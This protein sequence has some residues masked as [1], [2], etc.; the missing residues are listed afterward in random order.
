MV[1]F[2]RGCNFRCPA[3]HAKVFLSAEENNIDSFDLWNYLSRRRKSVGAVVLCGGE[4][5]VY[6]DIDEFIVK[7]KQFGYDVKLDTNG[8]NPDILEKLIR[9]KLID[10]VAMDIK[11]PPELYSNVCGTDIDISRIEKSIKI[12]SGFSN[13]EFRTTLV[14]FYDNDKTIRFLD[15]TDIIK[16]A[17]WLK[18]VTANASHKYFIQKFVSR[19]EKLLDSRM[20]QYEPTPSDIAKEVCMEAKKVLPVCTVR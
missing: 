19:N 13:Y 6:P 10:Y 16:I 12:L 14:P 15:K 8:G 3:C 20:E 17:K 1:L 7:I 4:P 11:A 9:Q 18:E 5:T 2:S